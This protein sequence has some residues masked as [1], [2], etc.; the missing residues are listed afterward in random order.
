MQSIPRAIPGV[1][2]IEVLV[3]D[4]GSKDGTGEIAAAAGADHVIRLLSRKG[5]PTV[6]QTGL[7]ASLRLGADIVVNIDADGQY[8]G[9]E[10]PLLI[11]P[12]LR[13]EADIVIGDRQTDG[14]TTSM[15]AR[16]FSR[17]SAARLC[18][19]HPGQSARHGEWLSRAQS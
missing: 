7:D 10:I 5:L 13:Q 9:D 11:A 14:W 17:G 4:D 16:S 18:A 8:Q 15:G 2:G 6:F 1:D 3:V 12:I 19:G